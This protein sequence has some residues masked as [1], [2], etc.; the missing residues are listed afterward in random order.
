MLRAPSLDRTICITLQT[1]CCSPIL[2]EGAEAV[3]H[4][5]VARQRLNPDWRPA[6][7]GSQ[8]FPAKQKP[9]LRRTVVRPGQPGPLLQFNP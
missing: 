1:I 7:D 9:E 8:Q 2:V 5:S 4:A 3:L 6:T